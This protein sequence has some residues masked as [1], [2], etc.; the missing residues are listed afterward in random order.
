M[1]WLE[2]KAM[3]DKDPSMVLRRLECELSGHAE[4]LTSPGHCLVCGETINEQETT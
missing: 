3:L 4:D 1:T 2:Y